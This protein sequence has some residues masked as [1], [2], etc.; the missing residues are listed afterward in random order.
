MDTK[1]QK[2]QKNTKKRFKTTK[3]HGAKKH[4]FYISTKAA[5]GYDVKLC[6]PAYCC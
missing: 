2:E 4:I 1:K 6:H 3:K 5:W